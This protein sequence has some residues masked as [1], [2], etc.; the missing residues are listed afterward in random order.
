[1]LREV[2]QERCL[3]VDVAQAA[4]LAANLLVGA[5]ASESAAQI[6]AGH[7]VESDLVGVPSHG[8]MRV[9]QYLAEIAA[10]EI[11]PAAAPSR[12]RVSRA[13]IWVEG[14]RSFGQVAAS[15]AVEEAAQAAAAAG[16]AVVT[17]RHA[18]HA[19]RIGAYVERLAGAGFFGLALCGGPRSGHWVAPF[20]GMEGRLATNPIAY[21]F[22]A[23][24]GPVVADFSTSAVPEGVVRRLRELGLT[25]PEGVL[26]DAAG[27]P[28]TEP[29]VLYAEPRGTILPL[30]G[31]HFGHKGFALG[32]LVEAMAT[33]LAEDETADE[34]RYGN[35][36]ALVAIATDGGFE[37]RASRLAEYV[38]SSRPAD[39]A[40]PVL[41]PGDPERRARE[42]AHGVP[43]DCA[44]WRMLAALA[45]ERGVA[46]PSP[47]TG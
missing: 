3:L 42:A 32:L 10:G 41:M 34:T 29:G 21:A 4:S 11:D 16:V 5:G 17:V 37:A 47:L 44:T 31:G 18:G 9:P 27:R 13:R 38:R 24:D 12:E 6:V 15:F 28:T 7:L 30:G 36:L 35:N 40:R 46:L 1:M 39:P 14:N 43:I 33:L 2:Q 23:L 19:G 8:L 20:G 25:A 22:P 45:H 26:Q